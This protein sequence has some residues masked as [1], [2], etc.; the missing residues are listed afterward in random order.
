MRKKRMAKFCKCV[1]MYLTKFILASKPSWD[2]FQ[3]NQWT[4]LN[5]TI[6]TLW[7]GDLTAAGSFFEKLCFYNE[8]EPFLSILTQCEVYFFMSVLP[9]LDM[10][11][12]PKQLNTC[13]VSN[14]YFL[15]S[16]RPSRLPT[17]ASKREFWG[18]FSKCTPPSVIFN[19]KLWK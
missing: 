5:E 3:S 9:N 17:R 11:Y 12:S 2:C 1:C 16:D 14:I 18:S 15:S 6:F 13:L 10:Q 4:G 8:Q 19:S 7:D